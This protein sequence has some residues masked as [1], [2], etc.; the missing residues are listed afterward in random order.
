M[1][2]INKIKLL[3]EYWK[4]NCDVVDF[5]IRLSL[6]VFFFY[7]MVK[8]AI[9]LKYVEPNV[10]TLMIACLCIVGFFLKYSSLI[11]TSLYILKENYVVEK[12][13][14]TKKKYEI[15]F[16]STRRFRCSCEDYIRKIQ[17]G[18]FVDTKKYD[19]LSVSPNYFES[20]EEGNKIL[21]FL[22][23]KNFNYNYFVIPVE[24][25]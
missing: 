5:C 3:K 22:F 7:K 17:T 9:E 14:V 8:I 1:E 16:D 4:N 6:M 12:T 2:K 19:N 24:E 20:I 18:F 15:D 23:R 21:L 13:E 25:D 11:V 10:F